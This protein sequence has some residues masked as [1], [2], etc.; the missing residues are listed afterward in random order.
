MTKNPTVLITY[1][2]LLRNV[3]I[4]SAPDS[5]LLTYDEAEDKAEAYR[6][7]WSAKEQLI[8]DGMQTC[9]DLTFA[10]P[11][12]DVAVAPWQYDWAA[13]S[14]P[15]ILDMAH[16]PDAFIDIL[17]HELFHVLFADNQIITSKNQRAQ[18]RLQWEKLFGEEHSG[19]TLVH[20]AVHAALKYMYLDIHKEPYRL[21]RDI[22]RSRQYPDY[23]QAWDYVEQHDYRDI[24][25]KL[26]QRY[27]EIA[28]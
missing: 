4:V 23:Q 28:A 21:T 26:K 9:M 14:F 10:A 1:A 19:G 3:R 24:I 13:I 25:A 15:L 5:T 11:V 7:A 8:L 12:I 27:Q 17:T 22:E 2:N 20:I 6:Q 18:S 16:E